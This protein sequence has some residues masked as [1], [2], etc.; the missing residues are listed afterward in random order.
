MEQRLTVFVDEGGDA[1]VRDGLG[2]ATTMHEWFSIG[3]VVVRS[4]RELEA[5]EWVKDIREKCRVFQSNDIHYYKL[6]Q[7][8][9]IQA[10]QLLSERP[11]RAFCVVSHKSN[12]RAHVSRKLGKLSAMEYYN[13]CTRFLLERIMYWAQDFYAQEKCAPLPLSIVFSENKGHN[14]DKMFSYF[15]LLNM[16]ARNHAFKLKP[17]A[18]NPDMM[19]RAYWS[20]EAHNKRAGLQLADLVASAFL[21][22]ANHTSPNFEQSA[23]KALTKIMAHDKRKKTHADLGLTLLPLKDQAKIPPEARPIFE[24]YGYVF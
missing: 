8:R 16:Q 20:I 17:K 6:K 1:G 15:E 21:Q 18:W 12:I 10:C 9:R 4:T 24:H 5:V 3:A 19:D 11:A 22:S 23:A 14:Y 2:Y 7:D 13:W